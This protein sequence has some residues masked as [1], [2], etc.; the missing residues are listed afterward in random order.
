MIFEFHVPYGQTYPIH[1]TDSGKID[2]ETTLMN[3][4]HSVI[5]ASSTQGMINHHMLR[6]AME[7]QLSRR[8]LFVLYEAVLSSKKDS[9]K[10]AENWIALLLCLV[11]CNKSDFDAFQ[12]IFENNRF[13][14][15]NLNNNEVFYIIQSNN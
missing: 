3:E 11:T 10:C 13:D 12:T 6:G 8:K 4:S 5:I 9:Q 15:E 14:P 2:F 1:I 7:D